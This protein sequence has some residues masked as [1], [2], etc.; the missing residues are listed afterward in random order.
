MQ[1]GISTA[2][3]AIWRMPLRGMFTTTLESGCISRIL[4]S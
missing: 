3:L 1:S 4:W 2:M